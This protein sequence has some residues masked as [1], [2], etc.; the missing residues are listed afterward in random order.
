MRQ[1]DLSINP[2]DKAVLEDTWFLSNKCNYK[3]NAFGRYYGAGRYARVLS[4][5]AR[6]DEARRIME[7]SS[8]IARKK[9]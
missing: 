9:S 4:N 5:D 3:F 2:A 8:L 1:F 6:A 7:E